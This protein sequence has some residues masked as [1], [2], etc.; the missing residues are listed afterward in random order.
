MATEAMEALLLGVNVK[1]SGLLSMKWAEP[2]IALAALFKGD[3]LAN[4]LDDIG[5]APNVSQNVFR[6]QISPLP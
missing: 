1:G 2:H 3:V 6:V 4:Q 5:A